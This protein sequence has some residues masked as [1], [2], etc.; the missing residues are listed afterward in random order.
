VV[1]PKLLGQG[2]PFIGRSEELAQIRQLLADPAC[3]L[4]TLLGSG[5][6]GK[7]RLAMEAAAQHDSEFADGVFIVE[8]APIPSPHLLPTAIASVLSISFYGPETPSTQIINYLRDKFLLLVLDNFEHL[9][10]SADFLSEILVQTSNVKLLVTSRERLNLHE[11]WV[12]AVQGLTYPQ[13]QGLTD[14]EQFSAVRLFVQSARRVQNGFNLTNNLACVIAI[15]Q[16]VEGVPL[17]LE[18]AATWLRAVSCQQIAIQLQRSLDFLTT[19]LRNVSER[20]RSMRA[21]FDQSWQLLSDAE[22]QVLARLSVF[23]GSF[24]L[25]AAEQVA[26]AS[27]TIVAA[28]VDKSLVQMSHDD[29]YNLHELLRQ[30]TADKLTEAGETALIA[31]AHLIYFLGVA[32]HAGAQRIGTE[33][34]SW[35]D[36]LEKEHDNFRAAFGWSLEGN[37]GAVG[38]SL[39]VALGEFWLARAH[40]REGCDWFAQLLAAN[41]DRPHP[42]RGIALY[43]AASLESYLGN[44]PRSRVLANEALQ[45]ARAAGDKRHIAYALLA[46]ANATWD[47]DIQSALAVTEEALAFLRAAG[48]LIGIIGALG[49]IVQVSM[50]I[51]DDKEQILPRV[52]ELVSLARMTEN[53]ESVSWALFN[54]GLAWW[55]YR[56]SPQQVA[57]LWE[58]SLSLARE[59]HSNDL[60]A[61]VLFIKGCVALEEDNT[62]QARMCLEESLTIS[63][64]II[65]TELIAGCLVALALWLWKQGRLIQAATLF[66]ASEGPF[67]ARQH[68]LSQLALERYVTKMRPQLDDAA[69]SAHWAEGQA[70]TLEQAVLYALRGA[71]ARSLE[72]SKVSSKTDHLTIVAPLSEREVEVLRLVARGLSNRAIA[73]ELIVSLG[74]VKTHVHNVYGKL[75]VDSRTQA[76]ARARELNLL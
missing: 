22:R 2:T 61:W 62:I 54:V 5:G 60:L 9:L 69:L 56:T 4:L 37:E 74:T 31:H 30:Y 64:E 39:A 3:R 66:G 26:A 46:V 44:R 12:L 17:A 70:M 36:Y 34:T 10:D 75:D 18:L 19:P 7:T 14:V 13:S 76:I 52:T 33:Q 68:T 63:K 6:I 32:E 23:R 57:L 35:Y 11:E 25:E 16:H 59:A 40:W 29:R 71:E 50:R 28:L 51:G 45:M 8:L 73:R 15:C 20:H 21:V 43:R 48:D 72:S 49:T 53:K 38:L 65:A 55:Q 41:G 27:L 58:E 24:S 1:T 47:D 67:Y 42:A